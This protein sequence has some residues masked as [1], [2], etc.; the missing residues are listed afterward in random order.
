MASAAAF[1]KYGAQEDEAILRG[2]FLKKPVIL[3]GIIEVDGGSYLPLVTRSF[4]LRDLLLPPGGHYS[5]TVLDL[6]D[7]IRSAAF[8]RHEQMVADPADSQEAG[9][10]QGGRDQVHRPEDKAAGMG[11][12]DDDDD[13]QEA[14][15]DTPRK[16]AWLGRRRMLARKVRHDSAPRAFTVTVTVNDKDYQLAV[17]VQ[18]RQT[19]GGRPKPP[20][21]QLSETNFDNMCE[22]AL[23]MVGKEVQLEIQRVPSPRAPKTTEQGREYYQPSRRRWLI[24]SHA[25]VDGKRRK[26]LTRKTSEETGSAVI[27]PPVNDGP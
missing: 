25:K 21:I 23:T 2:G 10:H 13:E 17:A 18:D 14:D 9:G 1:G 15:D 22:M 3:T 26:V 16:R 27:P 7:S 8:T 19:A 12:D 11:L 20:L 5:K 6:I 4:G 24:H